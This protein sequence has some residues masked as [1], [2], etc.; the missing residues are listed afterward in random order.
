VSR[1]V[2]LSITNNINESDKQILKN[3]ESDQI[4]PLLKELKQK[5]RRLIAG[6]Y[7]VIYR[8]EMATIIIVD[9][10]NS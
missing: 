4:E 7:K 6:N 9:V 8:I 5:Q 10:F 1:Q 2:A 3:L